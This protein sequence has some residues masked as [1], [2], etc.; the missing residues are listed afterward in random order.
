MVDRKLAISN[1]ND[2]ALTMKLNG[3]ASLVQELTQKLSKSRFGGN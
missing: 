2:N 1:L 3:Q